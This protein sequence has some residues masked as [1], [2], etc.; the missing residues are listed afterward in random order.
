MVTMPLRRS[1]TR[2]GLVVT[3]LVLAVPV[4]IAAAS[5]GGPAPGPAATGSA[6]GDPVA[7]AP[8]DVEPSTGVDVE[9]GVSTDVGGD[10]TPSGSA[11]EVVLEGDG[12]SGLAAGTDSSTPETPPTEVSEAVADQ[13]AAFG[14]AFLSYDYR[15]DPGVR[16]AVLEPLVTPELLV[17]LTQ[18]VPATLTQQLA[19]E[20]RVVTAEVVELRPVDVAVFELSMLVTDRRTSAD[21]NEEERTSM[22]TLVVSIDDADLVEAVL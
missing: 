8:A 6:D 13:L 10:D 11:D 15:A 16:L 5:C 1:G 22:Q 12:P 21:G 19:D 4:T 18:P 9:G 3:G 17:E 20:Q 14:S 7:E 2:S